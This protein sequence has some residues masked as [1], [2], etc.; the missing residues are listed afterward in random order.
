MIAAEGS[1]QAMT[2]QADT[3]QAIFSSYGGT[4]REA[5]EGDRLFAVFD[6]GSNHRTS[7]T[8]TY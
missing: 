4:E 7:V 2:I 5:R 3:V 1:L 6:Q 8:F